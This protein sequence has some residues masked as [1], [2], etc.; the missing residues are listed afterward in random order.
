MKL[1]ITDDNANAPE[2][3]EGE[4]SFGEVNEQNQNARGGTELMMEGLHKHV[5]KELLDKFQIIPSRVRKIDDN[6]PTLYWVHD[7]PWDPEVQHLGEEGWKKFD[8]IVYVSDWQKELY[9]L[10]HQ[11]PASKGV[12]CKNAIEPF[13]DTIVKPDPQERINII[14]HTTPHR[15]LELVLPIY[16]AL[17]NEYGDR[18]H[19]D[20]Y[21]SFS[22]YGW[23]QRD[24]PYKELFNQLEKHP[25]VTYHGAKTNEEVR[26]ALEKAHIFLYPSIWQ[27]TSCIA[28][29]EAMAAGCV[30]VCPNLAA[31]PETCANWAFMYS[32]NEDKQAHAN[33]AYGAIKNAIEVLG[34]EE[35]TTNLYNQKAYFE[36][37]YNWYLR[38]KQWTSLLKGILGE[39][40][41]DSTDA[42]EAA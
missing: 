35:M 21:S 22:I 18:L 42:E 8:K 2:A 27:E 1:N 20:V 4:F 32:F 17:Y 10:I 41:D 24:E 6:K 39:D 33:T 34:S 25:G 19:L 9:Q 14:Y 40:L 37:Y 26:D 7:L 5:D 11:I 38:G 12:V 29:I 16:D 36:L 23:E 3:E 28:A 31:L 13:T 30:V 15:G